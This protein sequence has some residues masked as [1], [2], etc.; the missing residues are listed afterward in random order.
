MATSEIIA[1]NY[2]QFLVTGSVWRTGS[3]MPYRLSDSPGLTDEER[4]AALSLGWERFWSF[5]QQGW[6]EAARLVGV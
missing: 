3:V 5:V 4:R 6:D 2:G 1:Y